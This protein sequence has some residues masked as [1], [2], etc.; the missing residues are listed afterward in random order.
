MTPQDDK[1]SACILR[2]RKKTPFFGALALFLRYGL[3]D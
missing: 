2:L 1:L 3:D